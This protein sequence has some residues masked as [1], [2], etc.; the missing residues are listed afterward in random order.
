[1]LSKNKIKLI[2]SLSAKKNRYEL[3]LFV[4]EGRKCVDELLFAFDCELLVRTAEYAL[5]QGAPAP[6]EIVEV[7]HDELRKESL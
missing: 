6:K 2:R 3:A 7:T 5:P 1:M 4:A